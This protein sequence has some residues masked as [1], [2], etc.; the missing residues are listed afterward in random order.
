MALIFRI[1]SLAALGAALLMPIG[2][3]YIFGNT[4]TAW[5]LVAIAA[6][7]FWRHRANI[8]QLLAGREKPIGR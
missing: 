5:V 3:F 6:L 8:R 7:L 2:G 1:S 4:P